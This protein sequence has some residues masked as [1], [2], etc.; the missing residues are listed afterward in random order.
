MDKMKI[1]VYGLGKISH[2]VIQGIQFSKNSEL[3][4]L[5][6]RSQNKANE[7]K[8]RYQA[9]QAYASYEEM[10]KDERV[11][12]VYICTPNYLHKEHILKALSAN[13]HVI[14]EKPMCLSSEDLKE[15]FDYSKEKKC[16]LM[17]AH[18]TVF[19]PLNQTIFQRIQE[20][21][22]G[23]VISIEA[24]YATRLE[25]S[26]SSWHFDKP[27][28]GCMYD[29][30]VYPICF[31]NFMANSPIHVIKR[32][33]DQALIEYENGCIAHIATSWTCT[34]EN[35]AHIY[36]SKGEITYANFWKSDIAMMNGKELKVE[37]AS[38]FTGEIEHA[39][40]CIQKGLVESPIMSQQA[41]QAILKVLES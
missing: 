20:G 12:L 41:S 13:K 33:K 7:Y 27:G 17:E 25:E 34:M 1:G 28:A 2:R 38:D 32:L 15:C 11:D 31:A 26:I 8:K 36:G 14:C 5:C 6:S 39:A 21:E 16:F 24:Q 3:Y 37:Q 40:S 22:I 4:A 10:L 29:I 23:E 19:T 30:G 9:K 18:K 35:T